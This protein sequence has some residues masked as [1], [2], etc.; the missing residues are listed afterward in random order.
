MRELKVNKKH[1]LLLFVCLTLLL[2]GCD[3]DGGLSAGF[4]DDPCAPQHIEETI[5]IMRQLIK[6][7]QQSRKKH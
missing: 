2:T 1:G 6:D 7:K 4:S 5:K 3:S